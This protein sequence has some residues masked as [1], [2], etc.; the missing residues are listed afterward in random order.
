MS[1]AACAAGA[2]GGGSRCWPRWRRCPPARPART[3][4]PATPGEI[5]AALARSQPPA[6]SSAR[7]LVVP[8]ARRRGRAR[9]SA[10]YDLAASRLVWTQPGEVTTRIA[11]GARRDRAR[12]QAGRPGRTPARSSSRATSATAPCCGR[13]RSPP[14]SAWPATTSTR[15]AVYLV[16]QKVGASK[17]E[18]TGSVVALD[19]RAG[20]VRWRHPLPTGRVAGPAVRGG[21]VAV[22]VDSQ[23]VILLD[24][25]TGAELAQALSTAE[26]ATFVRA[27]PEGMFFGSR[28]VFLLSPSTAR[29]VAAGARLPA[30]AAAGV[31]PAVLLVR[32]LSSRAA[33]VLGDRSQPHPVARLRRGRSRALPRRHRGR[34]RLPFPVR[35]RRD[36]GRAALGVQPPAG[37]GGVDGHR[38][39][40]RVRQQR[41]RHRRARSRHRRAPLPGAAAGRGRARRDLRR[42]GF[43]PTLAGPRPAP[44]PRP[45]WSRRWARSS[46]IPIGGS[47]I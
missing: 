26:A 37:R 43:S 11:V 28:G 13:T 24:G 30:G 29:G 40:H 22:P 39:R 2:A 15:G 47:P 19:P 8:G 20:T 17:R 7:S 42:R 5:A 32:P 14:T 44:A 18:T 31:R 34:P 45:T 4:A 9:A 10:A 1:A 33:A 16:V 46:P 36:V 6:R 12:R 35:V 23:Y 41:R 27:L 3:S 25:A 21:L 38:Q